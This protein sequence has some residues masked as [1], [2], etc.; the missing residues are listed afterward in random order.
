MNIFDK[1]FSK[2]KKKKT[3]VSFG[4]GKIAFNNDLLYSADENR[5]ILFDYRF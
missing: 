4:T 1:C 2:K 5:V 3:N